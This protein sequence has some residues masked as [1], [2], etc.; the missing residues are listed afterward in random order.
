MEKNEKIDRNKEIEKKNNLKEVGEWILCILIAVVLALLV[1]HYVFTPTVVHQTSMVPTFQIGD[2]LFL[3]RW[4][5]TVNEEIKRGEI[6]TFEA[7]T[8]ANVSQY[9]VDKP[10]AIYN[11]EPKG[12]ISKFI[13]YVLEIG[14]QSYIKR[15]IG[16]AG[17]KIL[18]ENGKVY[19]NG[20][21]LKEEYLKDSVVTDRTGMYYDFVVP[22]GYVFA[23]GDNRKDSKDCRN[24]GCV[25]IEKV[26]SKVAIRFWPFNKFGKVD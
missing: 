10:V 7:P 19:V 22:D 3:N 21:E 8:N 6:I 2:R 4:S 15:V 24:F 1:R 16:I 11:D 9:N 17:D 20:E 26:E 5:M 13:Y 12:I 18:I 25:P 14:K 23:M